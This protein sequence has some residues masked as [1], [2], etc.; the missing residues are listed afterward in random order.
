DHFRGREVTTTGDGILA[1][2]ETPVRAVMCAA[3]MGPAVS[4]LGI[5]IRAGLHTGEIELVAGNPRGVAVHAA[6]RIAALAGPD[7]VL[8]S[9]TTHDLREGAGRALEERGEHE[10]KGLTPARHV[11]ALDRTNST[12]RAA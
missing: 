1:V 11:Y 10:L 7:E 3:A 5:T 6:A 2:F 8:V 9:A 4:D 12:G